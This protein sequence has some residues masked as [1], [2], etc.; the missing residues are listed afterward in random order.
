MCFVHCPYPPC[1]RSVQQLHVIGGSTDGPEI[2]N[3]NYPAHLFQFQRRPLH[4]MHEWPFC[5]GTKVFNKV[6]L[7]GSTSLEM[8]CVYI[9]RKKGPRH[10]KL[11][12]ELYNV[13]YTS[14]Y[15]LLYHRYKFI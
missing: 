7:I 6:N 5:D 15:S 9:G 3:L 14:M 13:I 10:F 2:N 12:A 4:L 8:Q 1:L 11:N